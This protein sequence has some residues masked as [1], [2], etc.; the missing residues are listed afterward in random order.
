MLVLMISLGITGCN[1][2]DDAL[3]RSGGGVGNSGASAGATTSTTASNLPP[4]I[5]TEQVRVVVG[6]QHA[7]RIEAQDPDGEVVRITWSKSPPGLLEAT[8]PDSLG[9]YE[10]TPTVAGTWDAE[11]TAFDNEGASATAKVEFIARYEATSDTLVA[12]GDSVAAG[13]GLQRRDFLFGDPCWRAPGSSYPGFVMEELVEAG[14][15]ASSRDRVILAACTGHRSADVWEQVV[16]RPDGA[17]EEMEEDNWSQLDWAVR[18]NPAYVALTVGANDIGVADLSWLLRSDGSIR[19][20]ELQRR[21]T[22]VRGGVGNL[23]EELTAKT[24]SLVVITTYYNPVADSPA[25]LGECSGECFFD[26]AVEVVD[27]LNGAILGAAEQYASRVKVAKIGALFDGREASSS[28]GP[29]W[30]RGPI[31]SLL[32]VQVSAYCSQEAT[33]GTWVST[34]DCIHPNED[35]MRAIASVVAALFLESWAESPSSTAGA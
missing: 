5:T 25:G 15:V 20:D 8:T 27:A 17:P 7:D 18:V 28:F 6:W 22:E 2:S 1:V 24:D 9:D 32:G 16:R 26:L 23:L 33:E 12:L 4:V 21:V 30:I 14:E 34:F 35:G 3:Q 29:D 19:R 10:W 11:V 31:E 13:F